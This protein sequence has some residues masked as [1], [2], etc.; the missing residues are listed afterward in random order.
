MCIGVCIVLLFDF[1]LFNKINALILFIDSYY[2]TI[3]SNKI[4]W[5]LLHCFAFLNTNV[6][7][8]ALLVWQNCGRYSEIVCGAMQGYAN[9]MCYLEAPVALVF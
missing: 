4:I 9:S 1:N 8:C 7:F 2:R 5:L 3:F 6:H